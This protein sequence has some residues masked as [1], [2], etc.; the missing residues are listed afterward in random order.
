MGNR[1]ENL[2]VRIFW[3]TSVRM[4]W[5]KSFKLIAVY[6]G[7]LVSICS[8]WIHSSQINLQR[9]RAVAFAQVAPVYHLHVIPFYVTYAFPYLY[10]FC[11]ISKLCHFATST[12]F[13]LNLYCNSR[14]AQYECMYD[15]I[16][17]RICCLLRPDNS[18]C[19]CAVHFSALYH[20]CLTKKSLLLLV[21]FW[22]FTSEPWTIV[23]Y[24]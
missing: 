1:C 11:D 19:S 3:A 13:S 23:P 24:S 16:D 20:I 9:V 10:A 4:T 6:R 15:P 14:C 17:A 22:W 12:W 21:M 18:T 2:F 8:V 5:L 7:W